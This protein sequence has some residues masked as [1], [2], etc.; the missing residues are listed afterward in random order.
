MRFEVLDGQGEH[1][2]PFGIGVHWKLFTTFPEPQIGVRTAVLFVVKVNEAATFEMEV[3]APA[4]E[5]SFGPRHQRR[6]E[7]VQGHLLLRHHRR[8]T[9]GRSS[10]RDAP[11]MRR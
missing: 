3:G 5:R 11:S 1:H 8:W 7:V 9:L 6:D 2:K 10:R 4:H